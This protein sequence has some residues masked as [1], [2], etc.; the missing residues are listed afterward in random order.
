[1]GEKG[2]GKKRERVSER[3]SKG[4]GEL[5]SSGSF[6]FGYAQGQDDSRNF[7]L[8]QQLARAGKKRSWILADLLMGTLVVFRA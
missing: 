3:G 2:R 4:C 1:M 5:S 8:Q 7:R 6:P